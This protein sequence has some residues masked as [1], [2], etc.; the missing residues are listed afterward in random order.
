[1]VN[2]PTPL[3]FMLLI[4]GAAGKLNE[5]ESAFQSWKLQV[6]TDPVR[7]IYDTDSKGFPRFY[8]TGFVYVQPQPGFLEQTF[9][10]VC[11]IYGIEA[12]EL[13]GFEERYLTAMQLF[14][15]EMGVEE[16]EPA[17]G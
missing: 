10:E 7:Y 3:Y 13:G 8:V 14:T 2:S 6:L 9:K 17:A 12:S 16:P 4:H 15:N 1:M 11:K 5:S